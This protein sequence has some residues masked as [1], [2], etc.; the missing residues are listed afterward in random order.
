MFRNGDEK[1]RGARI[2]LPRRIMGSWEHVLELITQKTCLFTPAKRIC[3]LDGRPI[4]SVSE[5]QDGGKYVALEG[6]KSFQRVAY[7]ATDEK[8][9]PLVRSVSSGCGYYA[10]STVLCLDL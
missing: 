5:I 7:C 4:H 2:L 9:L 10:V 1:Y 3:T 6:S 8:K